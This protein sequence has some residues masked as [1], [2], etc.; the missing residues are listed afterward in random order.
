MVS[1]GADPRDLA[2]QSSSH[3]YPF[4]QTAI[5]SAKRPPE[6]TSVNWNDV[7]LQ[8]ER[9]KDLLRD[10]EHERL[11][12]AALATHRKPAAAYAPL[13]AWLGQQLIAWG[14]HLH[15]RYGVTNIPAAR[16]ACQDPCG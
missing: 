11:I 12:R 1:T 10:A 13:L 14:G 3:A 9:F 7:H 5:V 16:C 6:E 4:A 2:Y 15:T 8:R